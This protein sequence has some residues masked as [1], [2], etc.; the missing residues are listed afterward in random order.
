MADGARS[1]NV[2][3]WRSSIVLA[4]SL[5]LAACGGGGE[6]SA[7]QSSTS[8]Q[9]TTS[10]VS[11]T[12]AASTTTEEPTTTVP[13]WDIASLPGRIAVLAYGCNGEIASF[14]DEVA[15]VCLFD[16]DGGN[17][18]TVSPPD[19]EASWI[20]WTWDGTT[21]LFQT[22]AAAWKV[23][24]DGTGLVERDP[25]AV[26]GWGLSPDGKW[27]VGTVYAE[28]G[29][30]LRT[31]GTTSDTADWRAVTFNWT[32]CCDIAR[33]SPDS[34]RLLYTTTVDEHCPQLAI[35]RLDGSPPVA[36]IGPGSPTEGQ[37]VCTVHDDAYWSPD[38]STIV[39]I[40]AGRDFHSSTPML[41]DADGRNLRPLIADV[42]LLPPGAYIDRVAWSPDGRALALSI[43]YD[44]G[45]GIFIASADGTHLTELAGLPVLVPFAMAWAPGT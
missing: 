9:P 31:A 5:L 1:R 40:D 36:L 33:W 27:N 7:E 3:V 17:L 16:P 44:T 28:P 34:T 6:S 22:D 45:S 18:Q 15:V 12:V 41:V 38:G 32:D 26:P 13:E 43:A 19:E 30:F 24:A 2:G 23:N 35:T 8:V 10:A 4:G 42:S 11:P 39:F 29:F 37:E 20:S 21:L 14:G 25:W